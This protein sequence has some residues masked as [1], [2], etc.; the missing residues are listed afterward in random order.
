MIHD[1]G[2]VLTEQHGDYVWKWTWESNKIAITVPLGWHLTSKGD[3]I[4]EYTMVKHIYWW[5]YDH[6]SDSECNVVG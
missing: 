1:L 4:W 2:Y 5:K 3:N 6:W